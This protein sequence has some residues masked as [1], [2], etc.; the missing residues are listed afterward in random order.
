MKI[1]L[2]PIILAY[3]VSLHF[4]DYFNKSEILSEIYLFEITFLYEI[5]YKKSYYQKSLKL[6]ILKGINKQI[7]A[8][9]LMTAYI[10]IYDSHSS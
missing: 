2:S 1:F 9:R 10:F 3:F 5:Q 7:Q 8:K 6:L 4:L